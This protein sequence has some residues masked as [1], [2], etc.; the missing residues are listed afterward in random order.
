MRTNK[1]Y[2]KRTPICA[3]LLAGVFVFTSAGAVY[4]GEAAQNAEKAEEEKGAAGSSYYEEKEHA[5]L[6]YADMV[7]TSVNPEA[8]DELLAELDAVTEGTKTVEDPE[9]TT[10]DLYQEILQVMNTEYTHYVLGDLKHYMNVRDEEM[11]EKNRQDTLVIQ[12]LS[13]A[14]YISLQKAMQGPYGAKLCKELSDEQLEELKEYEALTDKERE[15]TDRD[16]ELQQK[17]DQIS[18]DEYTF[19]YKGKTWTLDDVSANPPEDYDDLVAVYLGVPREMN[20]ALVPVFQDMVET[21]KEIA[22]LEGYDTYTDYCYDVNYGRDFTGEDIAALRETVIRELKPLYEELRTM[23]YLSEYNTDLAEPLSGD[24]IVETI[25]GRI[26]NV[27]PELTEAFDYMREH[28]LY[29]IDDADEMLEVG[30][31]SDLPEYG[32]AF[33]FDKTNGTIHDLETTV[34]E[35]GH[36]NAAYHAKQNVLMDSLLVD[37]AEIQ[38]QG[39]EMLFMDEM[40]EI[41]PEDPEGLQLYLLVNMLD[42]VLSGFEFDEFQQEVYASGEMTQEELNRLA[43]DVDEKYTQYFYDDNGEAYEWVLIN[44][45]FTSPLYYIGYATSALSALDIWTESLEDRDAAIDKYMKL[46]AV[47][48]D[49]PYQ[50]ATTSCGLRNMLEPESIR[51]LA[52]EIRAWAE[53]NIDGGLGGIGFPDFGFGE[54][55]FFGFGEGDPFGFGEIDPFGYGETAPLEP[56]WVEPTPDGSGTQPDDSG[57]QPGEN[58]T[59][60]GGMNGQN[61]GS[62]SSPYDSTD[63]YVEKVT[64]Y[65]MGAARIASVCNV[66]VRLVVLII[67]LIAFFKK[68]KRGGGNGFG[69]PGGYGGYDGGNGFGGP[70]GPGGYGGGNDFGGYGGGGL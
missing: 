62:G 18:E 65:A 64:D 14:A 16:T 25:G 46:S 59:Q 29:C 8:L 50:E 35:F 10:V 47:P 31:T 49:M 41:L 48:L 53:E 26:G 67:A 60:P 52:D 36:F 69:G 34:H 54:D 51:E 1:T 28:D 70:G 23:Q 21:R 37:V 30:F 7:Y 42:S 6:D 55:D 44:H 13:D 66:L 68:R 24:E 63:E 38:S 56:Y 22:E 5:D 11:N 2:R 39:L 17:Y 58:D 57:T 9:Q 33:I 4:A 43:M 40:K 32:S 45:T 12:D 27:H 15:L 61:D 3:L 19:E 20:D